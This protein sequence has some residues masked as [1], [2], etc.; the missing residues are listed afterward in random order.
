[1]NQKINKKKFT[2]KLFYIFI[3]ISFKIIYRLMFGTVLFL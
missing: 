1:M 2:I 3:Y